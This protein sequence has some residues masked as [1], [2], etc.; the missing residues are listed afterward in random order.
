MRGSFVRATTAAL[1]LGACS[2]SGVG[3]TVDTGGDVTDDIGGIDV[4]DGGGPDAP[5]DAPHSDD[6]PD[7]G[8]AEP[9]LGETGD[10][11]T[12][13]DEC[14]SGVCLDFGADEGVCTDRC[15]SDSDCPDGFECV[16]DT[17]TGGDIERLCIPIDLCIDRDGDRYGVGRGCV[18]D[19]CD[20]ADPETNPGADEVCDGND[21]DCDERIDDNPLLAGTP[22]SGE[23]PGAC[24]AGL[25][26]CEGGVLECVSGVPSDEICDGIDNDCDREVDEDAVD[27]PLWSVDGDNDGF[28]S[29]IDRIPGCTLPSGAVGNAA[30][31]DDSDP[32]VS[33]LA[34]ERIGDGVDQDCDGRE[35][36]VQ[37]GD[38]DGFARPDSV[39]VLSLD[40]DCADPGEAPA[41]APA[42]DC[43]DALGS[44]YPGAD[45]RCNGGDD[46]CDGRIDEDVVDAGTWYRDGDGDGYGDVTNQR[47]GCVSEPGWVRLPGDCNDLVI[48]ANPAGTEVCD[49][50]DNNCNGQTDENSAVD[51]DLWFRDGDRDGWGDELAVLEACSAPSGFVPRLGDCDDGDA[52][53]YP[54]TAEVCDG[55]DNNCDG[56]L[57]DASA[58]DASDFWADGD[59]DGFGGATITVA[60]C[61]APLGFVDN[62]DDCDDADGSSW[63]GALEVCDGADNNCD[64]R[65]D[66][67]GA[68]G[69]PEWFRDVDGDGAGSGIGARSCEQPDGYAARGDDCDD[70]RDFVRPGLLEVCDGVDN[71]CDGLADDAS[72]IDPATWYRDADG[73]T[74]G[75]AALT[76]ATCAAP[77]GYV[78]RSGDCADGN[79]AV[80]PGATEICDGVDNN[81]VGG[82]DEA[83][84]AGAPT[85]YRDADGDLHGSPLTTLVACSQP[86]GYRASSDDCNDG[87]ARAYTGAT[88]ACDGIDN[89]CDSAT[90]EAGSIGG[91]MVYPDN[92]GDTWGS[93]AGVLVCTVPS[94]VV[95][96]TG[97]CNDTLATAYPG[98]PEYCDGSDNNCDTR[99][100]E[101][102][103]ID[104]GT[105]YRDGDSDGY[106]F[107]GDAVSSC[108]SLVGRTIQG[109]DC[110]DL[111]STIYPG[112]TES[113]DVTD[114]DCDGVGIEDSSPD[115]PTWYRDLDGDGWGNA[116]VATERRCSPSPGFV[117]RDGDC[118]EGN[119]AINPGQAEVCGNG[120]DDDCFGGADNGC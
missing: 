40:G 114:R 63:P 85:W 9:S 17:T 111:D 115:A 45:E 58:I 54:G 98:A 28:G 24:A 41:S 14:T 117:E 53:V 57:D 120:L 78:A 11:C 39:P 42:T 84:A 89:D 29:A 95:L 110:N 80:N 4:I 19:D 87:D 8:S 105:W 38:S 46:D 76:Q 106:G 61:E 81:C 59:S 37:D 65:V 116:S 108:V 90:D 60:A 13:D 25:Y 23:F 48:S 10:P 97:D 72:A 86:G 34:E 44:V 50:I 102:E 43:N 64:T 21:N 103:A 3:T 88:E 33:P 2:D 93:A 56:Q 100:D 101:G 66:E 62:P 7:D 27:A 55:V 74:W 35:L 104:A 77:A 6:A 31:C 20:D 36:C 96:R 112:A 30:D 75:T 52:D 1:L 91:T 118:G 26:R 92:D 16:V 12:S 68:D 99:V 83:G 47:T 18:R 119:G 22:C 107:E 32:D 49:G 70:L 113:C 79:A 82:V 67:A 94:G 73:D 15:G 51:A 69:A 5:G 71:N 109:R